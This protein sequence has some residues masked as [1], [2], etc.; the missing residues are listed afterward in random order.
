MDTK[1]PDMA[2][3]DLAAAIRQNAALAGVKLVLLASASTRAQILPGQMDLLDALVLKPVR[4]KQLHDSLA[5]ILRPYAGANGSTAPFRPSTALW[6][7]PDASGSS[8]RARVLV[9]EDNR[10][11][12]QLMARLLEVR[13][14][15]ADAAANGREA[16]E[17]LGRIFYDLVFMDCEMPEM[18]GY[19]ATAEIRRRE[20]RMGARHTPIVA[21]TANAQGGAVQQCLA[22]GMDD[23]LA[24]PIRPEQ[25]DSVLERWVPRR[26]HV[27]LAGVPVAEAVDGGRA[28]RA[29]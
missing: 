1:L 8:S 28:E 5:A 23:Y 24:K 29:P 18:D 7:A 26:S 2:G 19:E 14:F 17:A 13:G 27:P 15:R 16:L 3:L 6:A 11:N 10:V 21:L 9:A 12:Q 22:A 20:G 25:L 4:Q